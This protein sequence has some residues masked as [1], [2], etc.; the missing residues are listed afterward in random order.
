MT[1]WPDRW[2][3]TEAEHEHGYPAD[4]LVP[5]PVRR[6]TRAA[7]VAAPAPLVFR[8]VCQVTVAP[9]S[10][11]LVDNRGRRS[12]RTLTPGA[13]N[14]AVGQ[15]LQRLFEVVD[16]Q[17]GSQLTVR[18]LPAATRLFGPLAMTWA[19]EA[20][21][22][23][24]RLLGRVTITAATWP[25]QLRAAL[26]AWGDLVMMRKQLITFGRLAERDAV[27]TAADCECG[28]LQLGG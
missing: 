25:D 9:Y 1:S 13:E 15:R 16:L 18:G 27:C 12:P 3:A 28:R 5:A 6:L 2:G 23:A 7:S 19:V 21:A 10:Y 17:P 24:T 4:G 11:D 20:G 8:W 26:L 22:D 14:V